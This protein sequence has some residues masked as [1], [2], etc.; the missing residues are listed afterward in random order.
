MAGPGVGQGLAVTLCDGTGQGTRQAR[1]RVEFLP[2]HFPSRGGGSG[3][4]SLLSTDALGALSVPQALGAGRCPA[5]G[6]ASCPGPPGPQ[7]S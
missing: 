6:P 5:G 2:M 4:E 1:R 3:Y 7:L